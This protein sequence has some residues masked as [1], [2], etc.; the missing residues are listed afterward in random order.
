MHG[1]HMFIKMRLLGESFITMRTLERPALTVHVHVLCE[2]RGLT[3]RFI[4]HVTHIVA[5]PLVNLD[6]AG[7]RAGV[8]ERVTTL[9][10]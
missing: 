2:S 8:G 1:I 10:A 7:E 5:H 3:E 9:V 4:T 6:M